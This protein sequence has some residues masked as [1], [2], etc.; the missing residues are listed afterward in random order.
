[1]V[2][3]LKRVLHFCQKWAERR[4]LFT[5]SFLGSPPTSTF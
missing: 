4:F 5:P 1:M 2:F 3:I